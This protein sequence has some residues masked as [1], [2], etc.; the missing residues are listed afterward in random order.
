MIKSIKKAGLASVLTAALILGGTAGAF[1]VEGDPVTTIPTVSETPAATPAPMGPHKRAV[2]VF[3]VAKE[4]FKTKMVAFKAERITYKTAFDAYRV[5]EKAYKEAKG[6]VAA[7]Y[8]TSMAAAKTAYDL[9]INDPASTSDQKLVAETALKA[10]RTAAT[11][12]RDTAF[13]ALGTAPVAPAKP[14]PPVKPI[15]PTKEPKPAPSSSPTAAP[16]PVVTTA[17]TA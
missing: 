1:A 5:I 2:A 12:A 3:K 9:I 11:A 17:P 10:A 13:T 7:T 16:A 4:E 15:R 8:R 14:L 6:K